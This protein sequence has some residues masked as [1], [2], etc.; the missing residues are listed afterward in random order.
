LNEEATRTGC[1]LQ[2]ALSWWYSIN[3][4]GED[5][6]KFFLKSFDPEHTLKMV[7]TNFRD[8]VQKPGEKFYNCFPVMLTSFANL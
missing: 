8:L 1:T 5:I 6:K 4:F 3:S 2:D 7:C